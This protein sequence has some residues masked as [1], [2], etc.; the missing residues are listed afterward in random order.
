MNPSPCVLWTRKGGPIPP[1]KSTRDVAP[2]VKITTQ[3]AFGMRK[4]PA[5]RRSRA[6][7]A[8]RGRGA[9]VLAPQAPF[10]YR[11]GRVCQRT[12]LLQVGHFVI[13]RNRTA[14]GA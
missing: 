7:K 3:T 5:S 10:R 12:Q 13:L 14:T 8:A 9:T 1:G 2:G 4:A 11:D 6:Q